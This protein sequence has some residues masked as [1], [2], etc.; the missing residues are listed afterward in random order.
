MYSRF[1][2]VIERME[3]SDGIVIFCVAVW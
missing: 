3:M 1:P 2:T